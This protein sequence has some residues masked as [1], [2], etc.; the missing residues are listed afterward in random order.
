MSDAML[1]PT[2]PRS[3]CWG[4]FLLCLGTLMY[5]LILTRIFSV[6]MWYHFAS[7]AI[8]LALF[9]MGVAALTVQLRPHW[10]QG[11]DA[12]LLAARGALLFGV[13]VALFFAVFVLFRL[14][15]QLGFK[16][17]SF[18]H[19]PFYQPF[20]QGGQDQSI[21]G[22]LLLALACLYLVTALPFFF[23]GIALTVLFSRFHGDF[24]RLYCY[25]LLGA[26]SGCLLIILLLKWLGGI[27][28]LL[29]IAAVGVAAALLLLPRHA[30]VR[31][32]RGGWLLLLVLFGLGLVHDLTGFAEIR[33]VRGRYEPNVLWSAWNSFSRVAVYPAEGQSKDQAWGLSRNYR[34]PVPDQLGMVVDD[35]GYTTMYRWDR[36]PGLEYFRQNVIGLAYRLKQRPTALVIGPGGG[37]DV[38][39]AL[40]TDA[41]RVTA[42]EINPLIVDAVNDHFGAMTGEL[43]RHPQ[44]RTVVDEGRSFIRRDPGRYDIIQASAVFGRMAPAAGAFTLSEDNL[45]TLEAFG[46]Y[47]DHLE[48]DG[49]LTIS[50]FF[51]ERETLRLVSLGLAL[52][53][54]QGVADPAA[55]MV[56]IRERGLANFMLKRT[57]Y[58]S[59]EL[60]Q[61]RDLMAELEFQ[62]VFLPDRRDGNGAFHELIRAQG[63]AAFHAGFPFD[64]RPVDDDRPFF[65]YMLKPADFIKLLSFPEQGKFEDRAILTLR[66]LLV[67]VAA[68][69]SAFLVLPLLLWRRQGL[70][71]PGSG[72]RVLFFACLGL[73]FMFIEIGLLRKFILFLGPPIYSLAVILCS[74][75]LSSGF[76]ALLS[77][78]LPTAQLRRGLPGILLALVLLSTLYVFGLSAVLEPWLGLP[79]LSRCLLAGLL[80]LPLG[81]LMGMPLPLGMRLF[82]KDSG[83]VPWSWGVNSATSVLG[84]ILAAVVAMNVGFTVTLLCGT[85]LYLLALVPVLK[86]KGA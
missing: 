40:A 81:L 1:K 49:I 14:Y 48:D 57:P 78:R 10:F 25:D 64:I 41:E 30:A 59:E 46:D 18:F 85:L 44:V 80:L 55:H 12:R 36:T 13:S 33:F 22:S 38:L 11:S 32:R 65:Y 24:S 28:A 26:G 23:A 63:S 37:R 54:Q 62:E 43:Y 71:E 17:L 21:P 51:F 4:V 73:G 77:A 3:V 53:Q 8:S 75:L 7:M 19:Q 39:T 58:S 61:L 47:W 67:V 9:G 34:G 86:S 20:Q 35:T 42:V 68:F 79:V 83:A 76:G 6:L 74:L 52:L 66:N 31:H 45:Y 15:P 29:A 16:V 56:V 70:R 50:R 2:A 84:A 72:W 82:H 60:A 5:E 69:V 27:T